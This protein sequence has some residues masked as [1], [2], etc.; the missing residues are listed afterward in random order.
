MTFGAHRGAISVGGWCLHPDGPHLSHG[1]ESLRLDLEIRLPRLRQ[2]QR[3][4]AADRPFPA[5][6]S[7]ISFG[8]HDAALPVAPAH[9]R[10]IWPEQAPPL[11][12]APATA[13]SQPASC[14]VMATARTPTRPARV[15]P[16]LERHAGGGASGSGPNEPPPPSRLDEVRAK[17]SSPLT[18]GADPS[19]IEADLEA[20]RQLLLKQAEELATAKRQLEITRREY[21]RAH[22]FTP[23]GNKPSQAGQIRRRGGALGAEIDCDGAEEPAPSTEMP[24]YNTPDKNM[25][26]AEAAVEELSRQEGEELRHQ[27]RRVTELLHIASEQ[28]KNP[29]YASG[30]A[31]NHQ[32]GPRETAE[33]S[34]PT[35]SRRWDSKATHNSSSRTSRL[36]SGASGRSRPPPSRNQEHDSEQ[37]ASRCPY[38]PAPKASGPRQPAHS[39][40]GPRVK[41]ADARDRLDGSWNPTSRKR[42]AS[43]PKCFGPRILGEPMIDGFQL[44]ATH[45]STTAPPS[46][47]LALDYSTASAL[48]GNKRLGDALLLPDAGRL[49]TPAQQPASG[50]INNWLDLRKPVK[51]LPALPL[52]G[53]PN[54][55]RCASRA[56]TRRTAPT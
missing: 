12:P 31:G 32:D 26:A 49:R 20:H 6:D 34:S 30:T 46:G 3:W 42:R 51:Q 24:F 8:E 2:R 48:P 23:G 35:P 4:L 38:R 53:S 21:D 47:G 37:P 19:T 29:R 40:L 52:A 36:R 11:E 43:R 54:A 22:G 18:A 41:P 39:R 27:T 45:P 55:R 28:Q 9:P 14:G 16:A 33:S 7:I 50:G 13:A 1:G 44:L 56:Q 17:L 5:S 10:C 15:G 25:R